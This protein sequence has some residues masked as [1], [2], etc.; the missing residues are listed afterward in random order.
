MKNIITI[1]KAVQS[2][3]HFIAQI[4]AMAIGDEDAL[5]QYCGNNYISV[6]TEIASH[7]NT[8]YSWQNSLV[9]EVDGMVAG[10]VIG[11]DG[12]L[13]SILRN[14]T[15]AI[16]QTLVGQTPEIADETQTGEY[17]LDS[18]GV[19]PQYRGSGLG[20]LLVDEFCKQ[21]FSNGHNRVGLIVDFNN[22]NAER[23]YTSLGFERVGIK[24]FFGHQMWH[25]QR[26]N[27]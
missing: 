13:L 4:V 18:I 19:L 10:A 24:P 27:P 22:P 11:Y 21:A 17:Y 16:L 23:L 7:E 25:L 6:L 15:F 1:R 8:Q 3:A 5:I 12:A 14:G 9:A 26:I 2:D 20:R